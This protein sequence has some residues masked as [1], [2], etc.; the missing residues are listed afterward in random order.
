MFTN[1]GK[2]SKGYIAIL[3]ILTRR[4]DK[5]IQIPD[6][7]DERLWE[8]DELWVCVHP[9]PGERR[10]VNAGWT[11]GERRMNAGW[12]PGERRVNACK[13]PGERL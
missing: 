2:D 11:P 9:V 7:P 10:R 5:L 12:T 8:P 4:V 13:V 1:Q 3:T 6:E